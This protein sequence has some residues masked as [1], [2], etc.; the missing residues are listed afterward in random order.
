MFL[1]KQARIRILLKLL[2]ARMEPMRM[3][4]Q[5]LQTAA[6]VVAAQFPLEGGNSWSR[7]CWRRVGQ[8]RGESARAGAEPGGAELAILGDSG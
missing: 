7:S 2:Q 6:T 1:A 4:C 3:E 5:E 8:G